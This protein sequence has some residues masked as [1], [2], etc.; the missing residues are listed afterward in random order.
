[1]KI[2]AIYRFLLVLAW[3][4]AT[5]C[6]WAETSTTAVAENSPL[7]LDITS[8][9][10]VLTAGAMILRT[11]P[12]SLNF[13]LAGP[14]GNYRFYLHAP[15]TALASINVLDDTAGEKL[16]VLT[17]PPA[18]RPPDEAYAFRL[19][20]S[21]RA[22]CP[23]IGIETALKNDG[24]YPAKTYYFFRLMP[25]QSDYYYDADG[26]QSARRG[27]LPIRRWLFLPSNN[28]I[29]GYG[30]IFPETVTFTFSTLYPRADWRKIGWYFIPEKHLNFQPGGVNRM[31]FRIFPATNAA[32]VAAFE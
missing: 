27:E 6:A 7:A 24:K 23:G 32:M 2:P 9:R 20:L 29:G 1:M 12:G 8:N 21:A 14:Y 28:T 16:V 13:S 5:T 3:A 10:V 31:A 30:V 4:G 19:T 22:D 26:E 11:D 17:A 18:S 25:I 15:S